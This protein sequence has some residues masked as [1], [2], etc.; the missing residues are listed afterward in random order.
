[1]KKIKSFE[2]FQGSRIT[3]LLYKDLQYAETNWN[4]LAIAI[5]ENNFKNFKMY[6]NLVD[7]EKVDHDGNTPLILASKNGRL[8]MLKE[9]IKKGA[10]M[11]HKNKDNEDFYDAAINRYKFINNVKDWI[12]KEYPEFVAAKKYNL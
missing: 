8:K 11:M 9:L 1:M 6:L 10:N 12:E 5:D 2:L 4:E 7:I 3:S